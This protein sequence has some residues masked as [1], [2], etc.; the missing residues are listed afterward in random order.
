MPITV[1]LFRLLVCVIFIDICIYIY[2]LSYCFRY[3]SLGEVQKPPFFANGHLQIEYLDGGLC[4]I[5]NIP[6]PHIKTT[7][8]FI[9]NLEAT[10]KYKYQNFLFYMYI[11]VYI[12]EVYKIGRFNKYNIV[13]RKPFQTI[14]EDEKIVII[15]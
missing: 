3:L 14:L 8:T 10:V 6:T 5:P 15:D 12:R 7:I 4:S 2:Y 13:N 9:C 11:Y 1:M